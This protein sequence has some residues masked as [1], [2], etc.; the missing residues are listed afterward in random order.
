MGGPT[1]WLGTHETSWLGKTVVPLFVSARRLRKRKTLPRANGPWALDSGGFTELSMHGEWTVPSM[2]YAEEAQRWGKEIGGLH[3]A[4]IQDWMCEPVIREK[5]GLRVD[6][7]QL[8]TCASYRE[9][10]AL[11]PD[12]P[13]A[14]VLQGWD[15]DDYFRHVQMYLAG[16]WD[17]ASLPLVGL[18]SVCRRQDTAMTEELI[19]DLHG[20]GI[21]IHAFGLKIKGLQRVAPFVASSGSLS[22]SRQARY[23]PPLAGVCTHGSCANCIKYALRWR[24]RVVRIVERTGPVQ[25]TLF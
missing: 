5:T 25:R 4:A 2:K 14:P 24:D 20:L 12:V 1:F 10:L 22:W 17:L 19:R 9:L 6:Q 15:Y 7:H 23:A 8:R 21:K 18:G 3:W 11:A 13:W 16:G